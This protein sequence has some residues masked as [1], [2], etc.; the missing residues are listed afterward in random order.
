MTHE[1]FEEAVKANERIK[2]L[3]RVLKQFEMY[4][5]CRLSLVY[6]YNKPQEKI[7]NIPV[8]ITNSIEDKLKNYTKKLIQ[9]LNEEVKEINKKIEKI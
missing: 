1:Q 5:S 7:Q 6:G 2:Q 8:N 4:D 9:E 3:K